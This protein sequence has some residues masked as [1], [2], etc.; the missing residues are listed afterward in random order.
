[1]KK[2]KVDYGS[3]LLSR[4]KRSIGTETRIAIITMIQIYMSE[5]NKYP[6]KSAI[7]NWMSKA[8]YRISYKNILWNLDKLKKEKIVSF[9]RTKNNNNETI[10]ILNKNI[11]K[12]RIDDMLLFLRT[13]RG[14]FDEE[15]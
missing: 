9:Q 2:H 7:H 8:G 13:F 6:N 10:V 3:P 5:L 15:T 14:I 12:D 1:M 4:F 11:I